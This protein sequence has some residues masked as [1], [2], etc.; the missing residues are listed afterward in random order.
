MIFAKRLAGQGHTR[1]FTIEHNVASGWVAREQ[2]EQA[3][4]TSL[5]R[6]WRQVEATI[7]LFE[8]KASALRSEG[9]L[10]IAPNA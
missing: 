9:W 7:A 2:D 8:L 5:I 3:T 6:D 1:L 10:E 4:H